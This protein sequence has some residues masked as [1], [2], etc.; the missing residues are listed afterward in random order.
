MIQATM[1]IKSAQLI[2]ATTIKICAKNKQIKYSRQRGENRKLCVINDANN[3]T[4]L[5]C[6]H[7]I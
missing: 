4:L 2:Q 6:N 5:T 3:Q 1:L 7:A